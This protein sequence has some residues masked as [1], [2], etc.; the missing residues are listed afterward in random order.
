[1]AFLDSDEHFVL[2]R[3]PK[4]EV[5]VERLGKA[6]VGDRGRKP[7]RGKLVRRF[8]AFGKTRAEREQRHFGA[9]AQYAPLADLERLAFARQRYTHAFAARVAQRGRTVVDGGRGCHHVHEV[10]FV[11]GGHDHEARKAAEISHVES[12]GVGRTVGADETRTVH[13]ETYR[14]ALDC[15]VVH[16]LVV[17]ALQECRIDGGEGLE[18]FGR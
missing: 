15:D 13:S 2:A 14:Q 1:G 16:D 12:A 6:R 10:R 3:E 8:E 9:F 4:E 11:G 18:A 7:E 5:D 17:G